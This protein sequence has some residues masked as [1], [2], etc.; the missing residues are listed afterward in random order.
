MVNKERNYIFLFSTATSAA[1]WRWVL[2]KWALISQSWCPMG[3]F[4]LKFLESLFHVLFV[5]QSSSMIMW[6]MK[7]KC[8]RLIVPCMTLVLLIQKHP[9]EWSNNSR[10]FHKLESWEGAETV[11]MV[12]PLLSIGISFSVV[13]G[14]RKSQCS[15]QNW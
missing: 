12:P 4:F 15:Y 3:R 6:Y 2:G 5:L 8:D 10:V 7:L 14:T 11:Y 9:A 13:Y 1:A